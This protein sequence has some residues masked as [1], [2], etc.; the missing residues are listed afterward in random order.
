MLN[1]VKNGGGKNISYLCINNYQKFGKKYRG[2]EKETSNY[3]VH[4]S[5]HFISASYKQ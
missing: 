4:I 5:L 2:I 1:N 3:I